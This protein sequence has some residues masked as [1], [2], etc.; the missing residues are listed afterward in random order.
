V[1]SRPDNIALTKQGQ[2]AFI[3]TEYSRYFHDYESIAP[4][5]S[6]Q[7]RQ[8]WSNLVRRRASETTERVAALYR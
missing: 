2:F 4:Y 6:R 7:M 5:L 1:S 8:Y 3:D